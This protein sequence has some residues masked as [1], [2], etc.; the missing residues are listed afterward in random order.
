MKIAFLMI[1]LVSCSSSLKVSPGRCGG[2]VK[3]KQ[4][5]EQAQGQSLFIHREFG[6][7]Q[8]VVDLDELLKQAKAPECNRVQ[9][10][11]L[12]IESD[13]WDQLVS[14]IPLVSQWSIDL[15]WDEYQKAK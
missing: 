4:K 13:F 12:S 7:G 8:K 11:N 15:S 14:I 1:F 10:I 3:L 2:S 5:K 9:A 6:F